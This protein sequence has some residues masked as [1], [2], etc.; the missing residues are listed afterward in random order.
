MQVA[1]DSAGRLFACYGGLDNLG[2]AVT[3]V[4]TR[5]SAGWHGQDIFRGRLAW[6]QPSFVVGPHGE[7]CAVCWD[8]SNALWLVERTDTG[9]VHCVFPYEAGGPS[10]AYDTAGRLF[11]GYVTYDYSH[12]YWVAKRTDAV[13]TTTNILVLEATGSLYAA[14]HCLKFTPDNRAWYLAANI[15][16]YSSQVWGCAIALLRLT[17]ERWD[18][19]WRENDISWCAVALAANDDTVG[20]CRYPGPGGYYLHYNNEVVAETRYWQF[21]GMA[22][23]TWG[24]PHIAYL[25]QENVGPVVYAYRTNWHY[26]TVPS[27]DAARFADLTLDDQ[28]Q[29]L[30]V[31]GTPDSGVW[32]AHGVDIA[33]AEEPE[34]SASLKGD[35]LVGVSPNPCVDHANIELSAP[36]SGDMRLVLLDISGRVV[37][38]IPIRVGQK[39]TAMDMRALPAGVYFVVQR[40]WPERN[41]V[42][43]TKLD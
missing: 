25:W 30:V 10:V 31:F 16:E 14:N 13:W 7:M 29:P 9:W 24:A 19:L 6:G 38:D 22:Y 23:D 32:L 8:S 42:R 33:A 35:A 17:G 20:F 2:G 26:A 40:G 18:E 43:L 28:G 5:D 34:R 39:S 4:A 12:Y 1:K 37:A 15:W 3:R 27:S 36:A 41:R 21:A 11:C